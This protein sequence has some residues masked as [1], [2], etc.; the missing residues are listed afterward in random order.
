MLSIC[1]RIF[2]FMALLLST[3]AGIHALQQASTR[4][5][6]LA[7]GQ[8]LDDLL[9]GLDEAGTGGGAEGAPAEGAGATDERK[10]TPYAF[11]GD[12]FITDRDPKT[13]HKVIK[14]ISANTILL[15]NG[16]MVKMIG[17]ELTEEDGVRGFRMVKGLLEGKEVRL[18]F[19]R[20][21][22]DINGNLLAIV[23][24]GKLN[25]NEFLEEKFFLSTEIDPS[26]SYSPAY[27][28]KIFPDRKIPM[29]FY[30]LIIEERHPPEV[31]H[32]VLTLRGRE[33][34]VKGV[35]LRES[36]DFLVIRT[37]FK[38]LERIKK[39]DIKKITFE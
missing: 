38:G 36:K 7:F 32:A 3:L 34:P 11:D 33:A 26:F 16:E 9:Q 29:D 10:K 18:K 15:E 12:V 31:K 21:N 5:S 2:V 22:R 1:M 37:M 30:D 25:V 8:G 20:R 17:V 14:V 6:P 27:L 24:K 4:S 13:T 35:L 28:D 39:R 19:H 23:Y